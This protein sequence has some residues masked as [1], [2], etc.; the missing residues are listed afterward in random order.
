MKTCLKPQQAA[1]MNKY[2]FNFL[3][4]QST[5]CWV[6]LGKMISLGLSCEEEGV[7]QG[8][9]ADRPPAG[10]SESHGLAGF[11]SLQVWPPA[12]PDSET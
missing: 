8:E 5:H 12:F 6:S 7:L 2:Y 10:L 3:F 11:A 1:Q 9:P 4:L